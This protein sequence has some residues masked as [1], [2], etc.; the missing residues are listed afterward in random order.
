MGGQ[1][2]LER[3]KLGDFIVVGKDRTIVDGKCKGIPAISAVEFL[4]LID[5]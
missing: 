2:R 4:Q 3:D 1:V 5:P